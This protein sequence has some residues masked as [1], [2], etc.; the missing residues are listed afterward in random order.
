MKYVT[1]KS[2]FIKI[3]VLSILAVSLIQ[4]PTVSAE[5][6]ITTDTLWAAT[7]SPIAVN[8]DTVVVSGAKLLIEAG[9]TVEV[10]AGKSI[11]VD[12]ELIARGT[13]SKEIRFTG[14][15]TSTG[16][17]R[18]TSLVF[19]TQS[20]DA[21]FSNLDDYIGG[22]ILEHCTF[23]S[24][25]RAVTLRGASPYIHAVV[26]KNNKIETNDKS[27]GAALYI[28]EGSSPRIV[29]CTFSGNT[30]PTGCEGG[31]VFVEKAAPI[32]Q[33]NTFEK[34]TSSYGGAFAAYSLYAPIVGN[35]FRNNTSTYDGGAMALVSSQ[36]AILNNQIL[37]N[38]APADGGG[39]HVCTTCD[40][41][42]SPF[43]Y[44]NTFTGNT[45][46]LFTGAAGVGAAFLRA[47]SNNTIYGNTRGTTANDFGWFHPLKEGN[48]AWTRDIS[49]PKNYWGT[50]DM[51]KID[52][53]IIDG[54]DDAK[55]GKITYQPVL[56]AKPEK[57]ETRVTVTVPKFTYSV[58]ADPI[59]VYLTLYNPGAAR[60][61]DLVILHQWDPAPPVPLVATLD[62][63]GAVKKGEGW[64]LSLPENSVYFTTLLTG[65]YVSSRLDHGFIHAALFDAATGATIGTVSTIR[66]DLG[67]SK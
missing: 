29:G 38:T 8:D 67:G 14:A 54:N 11:T 34:N 23:E 21:M 58:A 59:P 65:A 26:F 47:F 5:I 56:S 32:F 64:R 35:I 27:A 60:Q 49:I 62:F 16:T 13:V 53:M 31:A 66:I 7:Q 4:I 9:V 61:V 51:A 17:A 52:D 20:A 1:Y 48:P 43:F 33:D 15:K 19:K 2:S 12:G 18:W 42:S 6:K 30:C 46:L 22:S 44:D 57:A 28:V 40:P 41:H 24:A 50:T 55:Y 36:P 63:P 45:N 39:I 10:A 3:F 37:T 25:I